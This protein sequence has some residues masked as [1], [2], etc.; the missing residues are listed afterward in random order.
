MRVLLTQEKGKRP[1]FMSLSRELKVPYTVLDK[2]LDFISKSP[3]GALSVYEAIPE[4][5]YELVKKNIHAMLQ[6]GQQVYYG[7]QHVLEGSEASL[8]DFRPLVARASTG[9]EPN[10][11]MNIAQT[12]IP[13]IQQGF[14]PFS[15]ATPLATRARVSTQPLSELGIAQTNVPNIKQN[16]VPPRGV[17]PLATTAKVSIQSSPVMNIAQIN[18]P[19]IRQAPIVNKAAEATFVPPVAP[20]LSKV[21]VSSAPSVKENT[22]PEGYDRWPKLM[23]TDSAI[24]KEFVRQA[25]ECWD[26]WKNWTSTGRPAAHAPA[27]RVFLLQN[28]VK[29]TLRRCGVPETKFTIVNNTRNTKGTFSYV[30]WSIEINIF[31]LLKNEDMGERDFLD[32]VETVYHEA[33][34]AEQSWLLLVQ[35]LF[36]NRIWVE[37]NKQ[38]EI[39]N[40]DL[41]LIEKK[42][43]MPGYIIDKALVVALT[44]PDA[45]KGKSG[46]IRVGY[47]LFVDM[48]NTWRESNHTTGR[49]RTRGIYQR[50]NSADRHAYHQYRHLP[51]ESDAFHIQ[52]YLREEFAKHPELGIFT[53]MLSNVHPPNC[54]C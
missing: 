15:G 16:I 46:N 1:D 12:N 39:Y 50:L 54:S 18:V 23:M 21:V 43:I 33:R 22:S 53:P 8:V 28:I 47:K 36:E 32:I 37:R 11:G 13:N 44:R 24:V 10:F 49:D 20:I 52:G 2:G 14:S 41:D 48:V 42:T 38:Y 51:S 3:A 34:H 25:T 45:P 26:K 30:K 29:D 6:S 7:A 4:I 35:W 27:N 31:P 40:D 17:N 9:I 5:D 19:I